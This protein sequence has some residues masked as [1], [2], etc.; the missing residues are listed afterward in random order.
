M[1]EQSETGEPAVKTSDELTGSDAQQDPVNQEQD[2]RP[3]EPLD[4][5]EELEPSVVG[6][7]AAAKQP[8][9]D[10]DDIEP[11]DRGER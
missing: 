5:D 2:E 10:E 4:V 7:G 6:P 11:G 9:V 1:T 3:G 8:E